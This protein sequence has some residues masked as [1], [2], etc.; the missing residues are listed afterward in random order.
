MVL[1]L[2]LPLFTV[3]AVMAMVTTVVIK[4][5]ASTR[6]TLRKCC[7]TNVTEMKE[8]L[9]PMLSPRP[10]MTLLRHCAVNLCCDRFEKDDGIIMTVIAGR[11]SSCPRSPS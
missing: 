8:V 1:L 5:G 4:K 6:A 7:L 11:V 2:T 3:M 10:M 9:L